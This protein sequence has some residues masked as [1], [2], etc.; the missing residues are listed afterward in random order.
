M[1]F[2]F[3]NL[4]PTS[5]LYISILLSAA[6]S[7]HGPPS[8]ITFPFLRFLLGFL[9]RDGRLRSVALR[10]AQNSAAATEVPVFFQSC[11]LHMSQDSRYDEPRLVWTRLPIT[12]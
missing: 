8:P 4:F 2:Y 1:P 6:R 9:V 12:H 11:L 10:L 5:L 7:Y 3:I